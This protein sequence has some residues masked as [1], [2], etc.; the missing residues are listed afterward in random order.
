MATRININGTIKEDV[1]VSVFDHGFLFGDSVY[2]VINTRKNR[3]CFLDEHLKRL[4]LSAGGIDLTIPFDDSWFREQIDRTLA[5]AANQE[6]YIRIVVTRGVGDINIDP[7]TCHSPLVLIYVTPAHVYPIE[8][9]ENGIHLSIVSVQRNSKNALNPSIKTGNYLNNVLAKI[10]SGRLGAHDALMLN[11]LGHLTESTT[12]NFFFVRDGGLMTPSLDCG[13]LA[14]ITRD[15]VIRLSRENGFRVEEGCWP[16]EI[17]ES[18]DEMFL[19]G[20]VKHLMPVTRLDSKVVGGGKPGPITRS[21]I[22]LY[23]NF[24]EQFE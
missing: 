16:I 4:H 15:I 18:A 14:G 23:E 7:S 12:S 13:I 1:F 21:L 8:W 24:L 6:S 2:E 9:Y 20:S 17:L 5:D 10:E 3:P 19:T 11:S 22:C